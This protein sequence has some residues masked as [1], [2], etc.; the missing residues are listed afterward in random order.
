[1]SGYSRH[2]DSDTADLSRPAVKRAAWRDGPR[3]RACA[4]ALDSDTADLSSG[5]NAQ[6]VVRLLEEFCRVDLLLGASAAS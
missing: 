5:S 1:M 4:E 6:V 3:A 2:L